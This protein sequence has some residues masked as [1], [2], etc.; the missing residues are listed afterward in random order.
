[1]E[2]ASIGI[3]A[4][5]RCGRL[6]SELVTLT[7]GNTLLWNGHHVET[8][9]TLW[10]FLMLKSNTRILIALDFDNIKECRKFLILLMGVNRTDLL[11]VVLVGDRR[12]IQGSREY[13]AVIG[14]L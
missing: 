9:I 6:D 4:G 11:L 12:G 13:L 1:M 2:C 14:A 5:A 7:L 10:S 8:V 3:L